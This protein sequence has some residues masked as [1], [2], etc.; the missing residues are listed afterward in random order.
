MPS[1]TEVG[2]AGPDAAALGRTVVVTRPS[3]EAPAWVAALARAGFNPVALPL[4][5]FGPPPQPATLSACMAGLPGYRAL[6]FVSPQAVYAFWTEFL[7]ENCLKTQYGCASVASLFEKSGAQQL[8]CWAPGPGTARALAEVG[9]PVQCIDQ[10]A[11]DAGQFDSEALW[12]VVQLQVRAGDR[13][14]LVRGDTPGASGRSASSIGS[15]R[16]WLASQC[17]ANGVSV[18]HCVAYSRVPPEWDDAQR[19]QAV[20]A[21]GASQVWLFSSSESVGHLARL[22]PGRDW[23]ATCAVATHPRIAEAVRRLGFGR[24]MACRPALGDVVCALQRE[25]LHTGPPKMRTH[26]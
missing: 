5:A 6:M 24:V 13:V 9:V 22:L 25:G 14:L 7:K 11:P 26:P 2:D 15:G 17:V 20:S 1:A 16:D 3:R 23:S 10:P 4:M 12:A 18:A 21:S 19:A 8:R